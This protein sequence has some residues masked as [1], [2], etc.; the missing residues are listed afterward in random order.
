MAHC[1]A[2]LRLIFFPLSFILFICSRMRFFFIYVRIRLQF[3][4]WLLVCLT[5][6]GESG[7]HQYPWRQSVRWSPVLHRDW[8]TEIYGWCTEWQRGYFKQEPPHLFFILLLFS[9]SPACTNN[10][11]TMSLSAFLCSLLHRDCRSVQRRHDVH[12]HCHQASH[13]MGTSGT[14]S[15]LI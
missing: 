2:A 3:I 12:D 10:R 6:K 1:L 9:T 15:C 5:S 14:Q 8:K 4:A 13:V 7:Q 11:R